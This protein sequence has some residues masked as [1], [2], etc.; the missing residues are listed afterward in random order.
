MSELYPR[1]DEIA[2][3]KL[4]DDTCRL[5]V[6]RHCEST[7]NV[8]EGAIRIAGRKYDVA[9]TENG[10]QQ[11]AALAKRL[12][13]FCPGVAN[14]PVFYSSP[15]KRAIQTAECIKETLG[16]LEAP[17]IKDE[18]LHETWFASLEG[19]NAALYDPHQVRQK[20]ELAELPSFQDRMEYRLVPDMENLREVFARVSTCLLEVASQNL[21][22]TV[23]ILTHNGPMK[24]LLIHLA[25]VDK[26]REI[27][28]DS[29]RVGNGA[30]LL[31]ESN[32][33]TLSL[34]ALDGYS[35]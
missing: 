22:E 14:L 17:V 28:Y 10:I 4:S 34:L 19:A 3:K 35:K 24:S 21:G 29:F 27:L 23:L 9:L 8:S 20:K 26:G 13:T 6:I 16:V 31:I 32:G 18:R 33:T 25:E 15:M 11:A 1:L 12:F 7:S 5:I 2:L 30:L